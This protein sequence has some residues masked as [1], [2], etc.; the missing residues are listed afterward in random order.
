LISS[1]DGCVHG[2]PLRLFAAFALLASSLT[3]AI[4]CSKPLEL[5]PTPLYDFGTPRVSAGVSEEQARASL[6]GHYAHYDVVAYEDRSTKTPMKTFV[7][8]YGFTD[9]VE[10][11]GKILQIDRFVHASNKINQR[12]VES[13]FPDAATEAIAPRV[14]E[15]RLYEEGGAWRVYRPESPLLLGV[16]GDPSRPL[17]RDPKDPLLMDPDGDSH[18]GVTVRIAIGGLLKGQLYITRKEIFRNYLA[19]YQD[20]RWIGR[21][22]DLSEQFVLGAS[23]AILRQESNNRQIP[24]PG[25]NPIVLVRVPESV[26]TWKDLGAIRDALFPPEP[27]FVEAAGMSDWK[28]R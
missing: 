8:S 16:G 22:E 4:G 27:I 13:S 12:G 7:V 5:P 18:P 26:S 1:C 20:G 9:F 21:V 15:V 19:L 3:L 14:Q 6:L 24:D 23:M 28:K 17:S 25:M 11:D 2:L 10:K